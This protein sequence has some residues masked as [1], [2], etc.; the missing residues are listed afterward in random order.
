MQACAVLPLSKPEIDFRLS[1][2]TPASSFPEPSRGLPDEAAQG[3]LV[4]CYHICMQTVII[5]YK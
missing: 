3:Y 1:F 2:F 4:C 5:A